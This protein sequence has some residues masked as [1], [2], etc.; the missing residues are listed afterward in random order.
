MDSINTTIH[1][2]H[3]EYLLGPITQILT[4][5]DLPPTG[6]INDTQLNLITESYIHIKDQKI[7]T[8]T[9]EK[10]KTLPI[11]EC[12]FPCIAMPGFI[13][14]H[15]HICFAGSRARDFTDRLNHITYQEI[16]SRGGGIY[17][18]VSHTRK[19]SE[20]QLTDLVLER[21]KQL[22][23]WG[24]TTC[25]V[26][27]G[28][29]LTVYDELKMLRS[30]QKANNKSDV[31]LI[32]T[33]LAAHVP[34]KDKNID[35]YLE[36]IIQELLPQIKKEQLTNRL[37]IFI[38]ENAF[39][40]EKA[41][42]FLIQAKNMGFTLTLHAD[43]FTRGGALLA[44][45]VEALSADHLEASTDIDFLTMSKSKVIP[46]VLPGASLGLGM[47]F[48]PAKK[49][50][51]HNLPLVIA[52]DWNP[53][54]AP[55]GNLLTQASILATME[56][57]TTAETFAALTTRAAKALKLPNKGELKPGYQAD[58]LLFQ[59]SDYREILYSQGRMKPWKV[60]TS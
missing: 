3:S 41:R 22:I 27:S 8:I 31:D 12:R 53:G 5:C 37:D 23:S 50:L 54:S 9:S 44:C 32:P 34:P 60:I 47:P 43:Q 57:L 59:T 10:S 30:I 49:I 18:T 25:E 39:N 56:G 26:K 21:S 24:V 2:S 42:P 51:D 20:K 6:H 14:A 11:V 46:I 7:K 19:A 17:D 45:E 38:E 40:I 55:M 29:G 58:I 33:C 16:L 35:L 4:M 13:D 52:S 1:I 28:Y 36:I 15:T 48:A